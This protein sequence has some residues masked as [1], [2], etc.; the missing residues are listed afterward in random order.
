MVVKYSIKDLERISG[1]KAHT[2]R[3]WEQ[4]YKLLAPER[5]DSNIRLYSNEDLKYILNISLLNK[6]GYKISKIAK[7]SQ[8][9]INDLIL[10]L[11][12]ESRE[13]E[14]QIEG[15]MIAMIGFDEQKF[16]AIMNHN[17]EQVGLSK[18]IENVIFPFLRKTGLMWQAGSIFPAQEHFISNLIRQKII[19]FIESHPYVKK[20]D[21]KSFLFFLPEEELHELSL[22]FYYYLAKSEGHQV[23]YLGQSVPY[24]DIRRTCDI[25]KPDFIVTVLTQQFKTITTENFILNLSKQF[26]ESTLLLSGIQT[27]Q[28]AYEYPSNVHLFLD[29]SSFNKFLQ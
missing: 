21:A 13:E 16:H 19:S 5:T 15:L 25:K 20:P 29:A 27:L 24:E 8:K 23:V 1:I 14:D 2:L 26:P 11:F 9:E 12:Q 7:Y 3:I 4:R 6:H 18:T 17:M 22:L 10:K 28:I